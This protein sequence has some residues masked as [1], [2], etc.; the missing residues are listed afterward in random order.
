MRH[1]LI[2][3]TTFEILEFQ[4]NQNPY[5]YPSKNSKKKFMADHANLV[6]QVD[7]AYVYTIEPI[8]RIPLPDIVFVANG[9]FSLWGLPEH[10]MI[11]PQMKFKQR[12]DELPYLKEICNNQGLI[13]VPFPSKETF[14]GQAEAKWFHNGSL[15]IC[16]YGYRSTKKAFE[17]LDTLLK[18]IY[19]SYNKSPPKLL[20]LP[21]ESADYY[22]LDVAMLEFGG[23]SCIVHKRAFSLGSIRKLQTA[24]G[25]HNVHVIDTQD[26]FCL[27]AV[28][29]GNTLLTHMLK[30]DV[31]QY[32]ESVTNLR[33]IQN[34]TQIF[35]K[36]GG[37][38]R[39]MIMD[40][41]PIVY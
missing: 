14:E 39:C 3:P 8:P 12:R 4:N 37:S 34:D 11:L 31:R 25:K 17:V 40:I 1:I 32:L 18:K 33:V 28:V 5:I 6:L 20:V 2:K 10:V 26:S 16:G 41:H 38:V 29:Q 36:S 35:E 27:N 13:Q 21:L 7:N 24:L 22:H 30:N 23:D 19:K 15:L 9:G